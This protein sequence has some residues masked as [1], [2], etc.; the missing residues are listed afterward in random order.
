LGVGDDLI[1][2]AAVPEVH[3]NQ[4]APLEVTVNGTSTGCGLPSLKTQ[5]AFVTFTPG[6]VPGGSIAVTAVGKNLRRPPGRVTFAMNR[7][8]PPS[9][10]WRRV[11]GVDKD[12]LRLGPLAAK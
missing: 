7:S 2:G 5:K 11:P 1:S 10:C 6:F 3:V 4:P 8:E 9:G 12:W